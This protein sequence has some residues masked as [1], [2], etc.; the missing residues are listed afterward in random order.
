MGK[1][2]LFKHLLPDFV[3]AKVSGRMVAWAFIALY[4]YQP[5]KNGQLNWLPAYS[6]WFRRQQDVN[7]RRYRT[8]SPLDWK[9]NVLYEKHISNFFYSLVT[10]HW[11][12]IDADDWSTSRRW[13]P[14]IVWVC[15]LFFL[16][17][18]NLASLFGESKFG[19][20]IQGKQ[21]QNFT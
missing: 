7:K 19:F 18:Q 6:S 15:S 11:S 3:E 16:L 17:S 10:F 9:Y 20:L 8:Q 2:I 12:K 5:R 21:S 14:N 4:S 13:L 1:R